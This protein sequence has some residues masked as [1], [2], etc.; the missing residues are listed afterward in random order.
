MRAKQLSTF[1][2]N[3]YLANSKTRMFELL[4]VMVLNVRRIIC[5]CQLNNVGKYNIHLGSFFIN[6]TAYCILFYFI[7][8]YYYYYYYYYYYF[9]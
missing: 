8:F 7:L 5:T 4:F 9:I 2:K 6:I 3:S 1:F